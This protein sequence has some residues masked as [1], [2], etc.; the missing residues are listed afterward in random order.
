MPAGFTA[1]R[2]TNWRAKRK[3][4]KDEGYK[5]MKLRFGWGPVDGAAGM[6]RNVELVRTVREDGRR[7]HRRHGRCLHGLDARLRQ[8]H[9]AAAR[10]VQSALAGRA[11]D[12]RRHPRLRRAEGLRA[13]F[14]SP[15]AST[16]SRSTVSANCSKRVRST[17][18]SSTPTASAESRR[19]AKSRRWPKRIPIPVIPHA[20]QMHN[21]HVVMASLNSP[22]AEFFPPV[23]VEVGNELF[24]YIF[25]GEPK[26]E[27]RLHRSG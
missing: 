23:D 25:N 9:A 19:R 17:T 3:R 13:Q 11:G 26:A 1:R 7:R 20:G 27:G 10:A 21:Y 8:A 16:S 12:S 2:S 14:R 24:W 22:M 6:Q 5:A 15:A 18:S 4:Y